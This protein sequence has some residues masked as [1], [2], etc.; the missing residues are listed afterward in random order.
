MAREVPVVFIRD[1]S[2]AFVTAVQ[3]DGDAMLATL[4][5]RIAERLTADG[6]PAVVSR[7]AFSCVSI[8]DARAL[9]SDRTHTTTSKHDFDKFARVRD[10][11]VEGSEC[12]LV[13]PL[14]E[15]D[16]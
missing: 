4:A 13:T 14:G 6:L 1:A 12:A 16:V 3:V 8:A 15:K 5:I 7:L 10:A 11:F 9:S 2:P